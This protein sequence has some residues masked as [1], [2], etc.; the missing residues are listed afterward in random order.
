MTFQL[1][2]VAHSRVDDLGVLQADPGDV[3]AGSV[4]Y[5]RITTGWHLHSERTWPLVADVDGPCAVRAMAT[6]CNPFERIP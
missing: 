4:W 3:G 2:V 6:R 5:M 1:D